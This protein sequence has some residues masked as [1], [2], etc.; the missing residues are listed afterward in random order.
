MTDREIIAQMEISP[1][2]GCNL[3]FD[4]YHNHVY[5]IVY[6]ILRN[7][8]SSRDVEECVTDVL[9][10]VMV[11]YDTGHGGSLK[12]YIGTSA[13]R[14]AIDVYRSLNRKAVRNVPIDGEN[15]SGLTSSDNV[16]ENVE[17]SQLAGMILQKI[18][19]MGSHDSDILIQKYFFDRNS[20]EIA[21]VLDMN[22]ITV[23]SRCRR[24]VKRLKEALADL[25][26]TL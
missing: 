5:T 10:D 13:R 2:N 16:E 15:V 8:G 1:E 18:E 6:N 17:N 7:V 24:A 4:E 11:S 23:R 12:A 21:R 26:I 3:L 19:A 25:D 20:T 9:S 22:P 14:R